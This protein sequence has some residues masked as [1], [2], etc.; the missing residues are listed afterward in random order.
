M[1]RNRLIGWEIPPGSARA[2]TLVELLVVIGI[3]AIL[4]AFL[5]PALGRA[6][7]SSIRIKCA[8]NLR[9][10][11]LAAINYAAE[12]KGWLPDNRSAQ[13]HYVANRSGF[14]GW[15]DSRPMWQKYIKD[16]NCFYCP[17][18]AGDMQGRKVVA[19]HADDRSQANAPKDPQV[20]WRGTPLGVPVDL[21]VSI[22]Y[23]ILGGWSRPG[24]PN[25]RIVLLLG[26][27]EPVPDTD[28]P[29]ASRPMLPARIG[30]RNS[31]QIPLGADATLREP[32]TP[33]ALTQGRMLAQAAALGPDFWTSHRRRGRF[34]GLNVLFL[35]G[36]VVWRGAEK[37]RPR[38][39]YNTGTSN[40]DYL[41][42]Y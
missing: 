16:V 18:F 33:I 22:H 23:S 4:M 39:T 28:P 29:L 36:H 10:I 12:N 20:G 31:S 8:S 7:E 2:F 40:Y 32:T 11:G 14:V 1:H 15:Y 41:Y 34:D 27:D 26:P 17:G 42:W 37:A 9:Q 5:L 13:P 19:Q 6:R 35:D 38:M 3:V 21:Y 25:R 30:A 24:T